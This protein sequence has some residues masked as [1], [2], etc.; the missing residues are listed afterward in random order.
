MY[1]KLVMIKPEESSNF[2]HGVDSKN[3]S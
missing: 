2:G 1:L 3:A